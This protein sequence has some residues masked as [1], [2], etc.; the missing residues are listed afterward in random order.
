[1]PLAFFIKR[2]WVYIPF[3]TGFVA[4]PAMFMTPGATL[5]NLPLGLVITRPGMMT[6]LFLILRVGTSVSFAVLLI[7]TTSWNSVLKA[8]GILHVPDVVVLILGMTYRYIHLLLHAAD[9]MFMSRKSRILRRQ[10]ASEDRRLLAA[11]SGA[12]LGKSLQTSTDV[13]LAMQ[14]RGFRGYPR[15]MDRF[16]MQWFDWTAAS[17]VLVLSGCAF[18]LGR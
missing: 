13:Y 17:V 5:A 3:F 7:L 4:V 16:Q 10:T 11:M 2:V 8:L 6:A 14:S 12:L 9:D 15:T 18:W 1:M